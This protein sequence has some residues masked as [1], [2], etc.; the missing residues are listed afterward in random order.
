MQPRSASGLERVW[1]VSGIAL[2]GLLL[3]GIYVA[4]VGWK[5][6]AWIMIGTLSAIVT[7]HIALS[8]VA[9]RRTMSRPWPK[10]APLQDDD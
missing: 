7:G 9:Y 4:F 10:V 1:S 3:A 6:S 5:P 8:I 2:Q